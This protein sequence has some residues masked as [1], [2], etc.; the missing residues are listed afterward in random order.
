VLLSALKC[1]GVADSWTGA[2]ISLT[3]PG[4]INY[5]ESLLFNGE[6]AELIQLIPVRTIS[7]PTPPPRCFAA[8]F[9]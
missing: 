7:P 8:C 5:T 9:A 2:P 6:I 1:R 3:P 4:P